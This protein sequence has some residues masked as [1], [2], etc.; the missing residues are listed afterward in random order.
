MDVNDLRSLTTLFMFVSFMGIVIWAWKGSRRK[1]FDA[2]AQLP[3]ADTPV[4]DLPAAG[5]QGEKQ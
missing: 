4:D 2:A 3:F 5:T 1:G